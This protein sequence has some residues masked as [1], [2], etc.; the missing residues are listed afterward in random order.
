[1]TDVP[2]VLK[3]ILCHWSRNDLTLYIY[4]SLV[5]SFHSC[6]LTVRRQPPIK[7]HHFISLCAANHVSVSR[8]KAAL[9]HFNYDIKARGATCLP[10]LAWHK[11]WRLILAVSVVWMSF[12]TALIE[13]LTDVAWRVGHDGCSS[14][15]W[16]VRGDI[17]LLASRRLINPRRTE[18]KETQEMLLTDLSCWYRLRRIYSSISQQHLNLNFCFITFLSVTAQSRTRWSSS[19][20]LCLLDSGHQN[21]ST[22]CVCVCVSSRGKWTHLLFWLIN[23]ATWW[24]LTTD[25]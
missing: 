9:V 23:D 16:G 25:K 17:W 5:V 3:V 15:C 8:L 1:M 19:S 14:R 20:T 18:T 21:I 24:K 12:Q 7:S 6:S 13:F 2:A 10:L 4:Y 11:A 22:K